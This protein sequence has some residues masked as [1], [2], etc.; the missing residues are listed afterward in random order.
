VGIDRRDEDCVITV[1]D[2]GEG[3]PAEHLPRLFE[4]FYRV[5]NARSR[6]GGGTG[7]GLSIAR[8]TMR[9]HGG[10]IEVWSQ[11]G[12]GSTFTL[13]FPVLDEGPAKK[14]RKKGKK[15]EERAAER[16]TSKRDAPSAREGA[17]R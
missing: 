4:R 7:L 17:G 11:P 5:D 14:K 15:R 1:T 9:G 3:I 8:H 10:D 12:V 16:R 13:V 2:Q 6:E